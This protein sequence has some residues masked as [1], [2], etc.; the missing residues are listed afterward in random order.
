[1]TG[2]TGMTIFLV[3][4]TAEELTAGNYT[5]RIKDKFLKRFEAHGAQ[6]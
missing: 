6:Q 2:L 3:A 4:A 5:Y 1:M